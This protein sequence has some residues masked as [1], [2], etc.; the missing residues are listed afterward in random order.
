MLAETG[1]VTRLDCDALA[2]YCEAWAAWRGAIA[3]L[4]DD[5]PTYDAPGGLRKVHPAVGVARDAAKEIAVWAGHLGLTPTARQ[6]LR[7]EP[8]GIDEGDKARFFPDR[9]RKTLN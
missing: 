7:V 5:G 8:P 3:M 4:A 1:I 6:K 2:C 9:G